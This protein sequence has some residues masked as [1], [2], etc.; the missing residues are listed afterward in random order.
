MCP[1][2][3]AIVA[4]CLAGFCLNLVQA[5]GQKEL[6]ALVDKA[7][8]VLGGADK[9]AK[10]KIIPCKSKGSLFVPG[11]IPVTEEGSMLFP[12]KFRHDFEL[13]IKGV[14]IKQALVINGDKGWL[15]IMDNK[16]GPLTKA[17][18]TAFR[19]YFYALRLATMPME[20][21]GKDY[22]L[23]TVGEVKDG[24]RPPLAIQVI[25]TAFP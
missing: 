11:E 15:K 18:Q 13:D 9:L 2:N 25:T 21:K 10:L 5:G 14:K 23:S 3:W 6:T 1:K 17:Q 22:K 20:L 12:D 8:K 4:S 7:V 19:H 24:N 16:A